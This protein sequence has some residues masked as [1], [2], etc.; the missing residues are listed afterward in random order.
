MEIDRKLAFEL[1]KRLAQTCI[2]Y[3]N[4]IGNNDIQEV[5]FTFESLQFSADAGEWRP[6]SDSYCI[7]YG[8]EEDKNNFYVISESY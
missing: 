2:D 6:E 1:Q 3:I 4:E 5:S 7:L 8:I